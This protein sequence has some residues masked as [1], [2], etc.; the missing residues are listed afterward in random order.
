[1]S[2]ARFQAAVQDL[3]VCLQKAPDDRAVSTILANKVNVLRRYGSLFAPHHLSRLTA[4]HYRGFLRLE[5]NCHWS[6]LYRGGDRAANGMEGLRQCLGILLDED[7]EIAER[8]NAAK[9]AGLGNAI[10]SAILLVTYPDRYGVWNN[11][12]ERGLRNFGVFPQTYPKKDKGKAYSA[13]NE[14]LNE[15][16]C[17][18]EMDLWTLDSLWWRLDPNRSEKLAAQLAEM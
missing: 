15:L 3:K 5:N 18:V 13:I 9:V 16:A 10:K 2:D 7:R 12:S 17:A 1:M 4:E 14:R 8:F 11:T 6:Q